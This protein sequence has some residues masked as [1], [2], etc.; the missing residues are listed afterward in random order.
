MTHRYDGRAGWQPSH[1]AARSMAQGLGWF[2]IGLGIAQVAAPGNV[3]RLIGVGDDD[4]NR[5]VVRAVGL[6]EIASGMGL[7][8][9]AR[10]A[11]W[12]WA[13]SRALRSSTSTPRACSYSRSNA[14]VSACS[15]WLL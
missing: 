14:S 3:A 4:E 6:R 9:R 2:S 12:A 10:P 8:G 7:L 5:G 13:R 15:R 1:D 11:G